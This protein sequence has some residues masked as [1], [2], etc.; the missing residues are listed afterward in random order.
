MSPQIDKSNIMSTISSLIHNSRLSESD[1]ADKVGVSRQ[2]IFKWRTQKVSSIRKSNLVS[3]AEA[4]DHTIEFNGNEIELDKMEIELDEGGMEMSLMAQDLIKQKDRYI[5]LL[6]K[7]VEE[8]DVRLEA[9]NEALHSLDNTIKSQ[10][11]T[12]Q[13]L[14]VNPID[15]NL[16][17]SRM[18]FIVNTEKKNF[19]SCTQ[20][21]ADIYELT[22]SD[23]VNDK[24]WGLIVSKED[25][26]RLPIIE[27]YGLDSDD[28]GK[29]RRQNTWLVDA[30]NGNKARYLKTNAVILDDKG[31]FKRIDCVK[32][33]KEE[34]E[35][36]NDFYRSFEKHKD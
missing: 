33:T 26:W 11:E 13:N 17:Y 9:C 14:S 10:A 20:K 31:I 32:S 5:A 34:W 27:A 29:N 6:E 7:T 36:S 22:Q 15:M 2:M 4:L 35:A 30:M 16:D 25:F 8:K 19:H 18:Q 24:D 3:L 12:I 1:L 21:Y 23:I 28:Y